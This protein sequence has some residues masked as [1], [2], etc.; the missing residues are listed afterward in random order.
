[1]SP[2]DGG[3]DGDGIDRLEHATARLEAIAAEL[4]GADLADAATVE[5][6]REAAEIAAD[7]GAVAAEA[8]RAAAERGAEPG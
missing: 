2:G 6:A 8:A 7:V 5:L 4:E 1:M 3:G